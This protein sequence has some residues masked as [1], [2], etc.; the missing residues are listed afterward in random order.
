MSWPIDA[1]ARY[2]ESRPALVDAID[3]Q[4]PPEKPGLHL[5]VRGDGY[6]IAGGTFCHLSI[7]LA[8]HGKDARRPAMVWT[9]GLATCPD[10]DMQD[11]GVLWA[12]NLQVCAL[13]HR[14]HTGKGANVYIWRAGSDL[15]FIW[16]TEIV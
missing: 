8:N 14:K 2:I 5:I 16:C 7:G 3:F 4:G 13:Q 6:P 10:K 12:K 9:I 15:V 1:W 11:L